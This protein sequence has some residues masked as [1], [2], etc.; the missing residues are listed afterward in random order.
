VETTIAAAKR[1]TV[2]LVLGSGG[3]RGLTHIGIIR[4][5]EENGFA[6]QSIAGCSIGALIG[7]VYAAGKLA[8]T[9][10][11]LRAVTKLDILALMDLSWQKSG[12]LRGDKLIGMLADL[13]GGK[14]IEELPIS[15][16]AVATDISAHKEV[17]IRRGDLFSAIRASISIPILFTPFRY[18]DMDLVDGGLLN[19]V[20]IAPTFG[21]GTDL[22]IAVNLGGAPCLPVPPRRPATV[23]VRP[24]AALHEKISLFIDRL[25]PATRKTSE[26]DWGAYQ[27]LLRSFDT[28]QSAI[29]R[30]QLA[31]YPPDVVIEMP[32]NIC[33]TLEFDRAA[34]MIDL[35]YRR[36]Q[37][38]LA[39]HVAGPPSSANAV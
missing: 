14:S 31:A 7:G 23:P 30:H 3:A 2:S 13:I 6:I 27:I 24:A 32:N 34:E 9:E 5:L 36:A 15:Y 35:G 38:C 16:T 33:Q 28:M 10:Q 8:E 12:V 18:K 26:H 20:P 29:A 19:P 39:N 22:T 25:Q 1:Q 17:W 37:E 11:W 21:D 4:W